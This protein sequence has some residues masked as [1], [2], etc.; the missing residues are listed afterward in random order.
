MG[1]GEDT[2]E[3]RDTGNIRALQGTVGSRYELVS[4]RIGSRLLRAEGRWGQTDEFI[5]TT[6]VEAIILSL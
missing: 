1:E 6:E 2:G 4:D 3:R 5:D